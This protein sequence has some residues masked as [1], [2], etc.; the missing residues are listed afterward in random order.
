[1][2]IPVFPGI[3]VRLFDIHLRFIRFCRGF[4]KTIDDDHAPVALVLDGAGSHD[5]RRRTFLP[6]EPPKSMRCTAIGA[7]TGIIPGA[8]AGTESLWTSSAPPGRSPI[9]GWFSA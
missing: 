1:M 6:S 9:T 5:A 7:A 2:S 4:Y 8:V 3:Y